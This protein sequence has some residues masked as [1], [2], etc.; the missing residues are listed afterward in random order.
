MHY[1]VILLSLQWRI[2]CQTMKRFLIFVMLFLAAASTLAAQDIIQT[3]K[4][5]LIEATAVIFGPSRISYKLYSEPSGEMY[6]IDTDQVAKIYFENGEKMDLLVSSSMGDSKYYSNLRHYFN[7]SQYVPM[8]GDPY[9]PTLM[10]VTSFIIPGLGQCLEGEWGTGALMLIGEASL[11]YMVYAS[12]QTQNKVYEDTG[13]SSQTVQVRVHATVGTV[14]AVAGLLALNS[15]SAYDA[16]RI[17]K[18]KNMH[19]QSLTVAPDLG[20]VETPAGLSAAP[21]LSLRINF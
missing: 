9:N 10:G 11:A 12:L 4:G 3:R 8:Q 21:S 18:V 5:A 17:A 20:F 6:F 13:Q 2:I 1:D 19:H 15:F 16:V 7:P 14:F